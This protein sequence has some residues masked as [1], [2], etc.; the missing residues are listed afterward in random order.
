MPLG[1]R[2]VVACVSVYGATNISVLHPEQAANIQ[3]IGTTLLSRPV[4]LTF[5]AL[6]TGL[7]GWMPA[8]GSCCSLGARVGVGRQGRAALQTLQWQAT[9]IGS[10]P[11]WHLLKPCT[12]AG[13][14]GAAGINVQCQWCTEELRCK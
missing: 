11:C 8:E 13:R 14:P 5:G 2:G 12:Q 4:C 7:I 1:M 6:G 9:D 3:G 10:T